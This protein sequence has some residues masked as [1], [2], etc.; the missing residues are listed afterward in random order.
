VERK[1]RIQVGDEAV[2]VTE[3]GYRTMGE[4]WNEY[5]ADDGSVIRVKLIV[6][7]VLRVDDKYDEQGNPVYMVRSSNVMST[8]SPEELRRGNP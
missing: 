4:P 8:S 1:K 2:D 5:L 3:L 7:E 6:T